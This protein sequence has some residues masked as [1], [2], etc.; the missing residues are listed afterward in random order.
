MRQRSVYPRMKL[1]DRPLDYIQKSH[2]KE[3]D[4]AN[5]SAEEVDAEMMLKTLPVSGM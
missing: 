2:Y 5:P 1:K 4:P 3:V